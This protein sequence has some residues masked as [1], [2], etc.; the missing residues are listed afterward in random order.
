VLG[1][2]Q[3]TSIESVRSQFGKPVSEF[4]QGKEAVLYYGTWQLEFA[5]GRLKRKTRYFRVKQGKESPIREASR[6][7][8]EALDRE[9]LML[10]PGMSIAVVRARL[11][12]PKGREEEFEGTGRRQ[13][14]RYGVWELVFSEGRLTRRTKG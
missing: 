13:I 4:S 1:L 12:P 3:G 10:H 11:G 6:R 14:L 7:E 8:G 9:V 2:D 5:N